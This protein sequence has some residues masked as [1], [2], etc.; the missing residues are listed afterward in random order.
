MHV[1]SFALVSLL[2][3]GPTMAVFRRDEDNNNHNAPARVRIARNLMKS[4]SDSN[5]KGGMM[6]MKDKTMKMM[7]TEEVAVNATTPIP[8]EEFL[9]S[10][11]GMMMMNKGENSGKSGKMGKGGKG[12]SMI[13]T[14][15]PAAAMFEIVNTCVTEGNCIRATDGALY[16][17]SENCEWA[18]S[19][20]ATLAVTFFELEDVF[21]FVF[22]NDGLPGELPGFTDTGINADGLAI[23]GLAVAAGDVITFRSDGT[24]QRAG[25]EICLV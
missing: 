13:T 10:S 4:K 8:E 19:A 3:I 1:R 11:K 23:D 17:N 7:A 20:N 22:I 25:F 9:S 2:L 5:S 21:D 16:D 12:K 24:G 6:M 14:E 15:P 18:I